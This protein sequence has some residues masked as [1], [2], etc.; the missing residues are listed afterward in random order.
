MTIDLWG[1]GLQAINVLIL[2]WLL[3]RFLW[4][5]VANAI[6]QRQDAV[7]AMLDDA[8]ATQTQT[9]E[10]R[11]EVDKARAGIAAERE[12]L[13]AEAA[14]QAEIAKAAALALARQEAAKLVQGAQLA[15]DRDTETFRK[16]NAAKSA[17][18]AVEIARKLLER[19]ETASVQNAF[20]AFLI[21]AIDNMPEKDRA[22]LAGGADGI[23]LISAKE[24]TDSDKASITKALNDALGGAGALTFA[25]DPGLISG[26]EI[27]TAHFSL[28]NSWRADLDRILSDVKNAT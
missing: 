6:A 22:A 19:L 10:A 27:R 7:R 23:D 5:P 17:E 28:H 1:L 26:F 20:Q 11:A 12:T 14:A 2:V 15:R 3:S 8:T 18:L 4:R 13:L 25:T 9:A 16:E 24:L 21:D